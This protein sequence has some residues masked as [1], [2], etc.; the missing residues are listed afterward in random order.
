MTGD[1]D[2]PKSS[3]PGGTLGTVGAFQLIERLPRT[4]EVREFLARQRGPGGFERICA[5]KLASRG[6]S[7]R[8][9]A[10][11]LEREAKVM[12][13]LDHPNVVRF[14]DF[15]EHDDDIV[16]VLEHFSGLTLARLLELLRENGEPVD[17]RIAWHVAHCLF[18]ALAHAHGLVDAAGMTVP[19]I[20]RDV[21]PENVLVSS[22]G[23]V[24]LTGFSAAQDADS[25]EEITAF[26]ALI[27][28][29]SFVAPEQVRGLEATERSD[30]YAAALV[31]W[32]L[33]TGRSATPEGLSEFDLLKALSMRQVEPLRALRPDIPALVT[34]ALDLCLT[35]DPEERRIRCEEVAGCITAGLDAGDGA[36]ALREAIAK[37]GPAVQ[38][39]AGGVAASLPPSRRRPGS[40]PPLPH[41][42]E[43]ITLPEQVRISPRME[44]AVTAIPLA[45]SQRV[46]VPRQQLSSLFDE[47][48]VQMPIPSCPA[49][50]DN[51]DDDD[52]SNDVVVVPP[53][54]PPPP[55]QSAARPI[56]P[57]SSPPPG[58]T[59][60]P[61]E[62]LLCS[63]VPS[64]P[65]LSEARVSNSSIEPSAS[66]AAVLVGSTPD[67]FTE[68]EFPVADDELIAL[69]ARQKRRQVVRVAVI[70][71]PV[72]A[73]A[74]I[75]LA[76]MSGGIGGGSENVGFR[77]ATVVASAP[78]NTEVRAPATP[79]VPVA[80]SAS[81]AQ[82]APPDQAVLVVEGPPGG[83][84]YVTG[85]PLGATDTR[86]VT[87]C[88]QRFIRVGTK[89][90]GAGLSSVRWL[91]EGQSIG[92]KCGETTKVPADPDRTRRP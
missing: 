63:S 77:P 46:S 75:L 20:H 85:K 81:V 39:L 92:L 71:V 69:R 27:R 23:R 35:S 33:L 83:F 7:D 73:T 40:A 50:D 31:V 15:F 38:K 79:T 78:R 90:G 84:V 57:A 26:G 32:E 51:E 19:V 49:D 70:G 14:H 60:Q 58:P 88:G 80:T 16:L 11:A 34:T 54:P 1:S 76:A 8:R 59:A 61:T 89:M 28:V 18:E 68:T 44:A 72:A 4:R 25:N 45:P 41:R 66:G 53:P 6:A 24:R 56:V 10:E 3:A 21:R 62:D 64:Y 43:A 36:L 13:R 12:M 67:S 47:N 42:P 52:V 17:E 82:P 74:I 30:A 5:L 86:I 48:T 2:A 55:A 87:D 22:N 9:A 29:P 37:L 91:A 65:A